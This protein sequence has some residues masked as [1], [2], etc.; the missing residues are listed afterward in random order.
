MSKKSVIFCFLVT[1]AW[2]ALLALPA[3]AEPPDPPLPGEKAASSDYVPAV[4]QDPVGP[5]DPSKFIPVAGSPEKVN[6]DPAVVIDMRRIP[7]TPDLTK[8][9]GRDRV[10]RQGQFEQSGPPPTRKWSRAPLAHS[11]HDTPMAEIEHPETKAVGPD[12]TKAAGDYIVGFNARGY[13]GWIPPDT[14]MAAGPEYLVEAVNSGF[15]VYSKTGTLTRAYTNFET[16]VNLPAPWNG[17][18]YD[19]RIMTDQQKGSSKFFCHPM[20]QV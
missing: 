16:F 12:A 2:L 5:Q 6:V 13:T 3:T 17:F 7:V 20:Y 14:Q 15:M 18:C 11:E 8:S 4:E 19:P 10:H 9:D 1:A